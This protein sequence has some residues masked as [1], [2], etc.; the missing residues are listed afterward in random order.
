MWR[1]RL[2][3]RSDMRVRVLET[4]VR[5]P[6]GVIKFGVSSIPRWVNTVLLVVATRVRAPVGPEKKRPGE[7]EILSV[8]GLKTRFLSRENRFLRDRTCFGKGMRRRW[9]PRGAGAARRAGTVP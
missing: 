5:V 1:A 2:A 6:M 4:R 3:E 9:F 7:L 8:R